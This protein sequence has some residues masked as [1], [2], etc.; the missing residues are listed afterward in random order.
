MVCSGVACG[1][2][3]WQGLCWAVFGVAMAVGWYLAPKPGD[4]HLGI[5]GGCAVSFA[6]GV[7]NTVSSLFTPITIRTSHVSGTV[8]D[9][10]IGL[11]Q[12]LRDGNL[13][14]LWKAKFHLPNLLAFWVGALAGTVGY[15]HYGHNALLANVAFGLIVG[16]V[17]IVLG[18]GA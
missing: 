13:N 11:G 7:Q 18:T 9:A 15:N 2:G 14:N 10:G 12:C 8:L 5:P 1:V 4:T 17:S 6:M 16:L 3:W